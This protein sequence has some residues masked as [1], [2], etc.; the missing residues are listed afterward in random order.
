[1]SSGHDEH[2]ALRRLALLMQANPNVAAC[3][4]R[5]PDGAATAH[6]QYAILLNERDCATLRSLQLCSRT[7]GDFLA[8]LVEI[9]DGPLSAT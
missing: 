7:V 4:L 1:M 8:G 2:S 6:P 3:V 9:V 5:D